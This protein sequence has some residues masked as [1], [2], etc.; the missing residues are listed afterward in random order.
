MNNEMKILIPNEFLKMNSMPND[1][2]QST[3][4]GKQT[5]SANCFLMVYPIPIQNAMPFGNN[6]AV[7]N[8]IHQTLGND[9]GLIEVGSGN[10]VNGK[11]YIYSIVKTKMNP[12][13]V[14]YCLVMHIGENNSVMQ[15]QGF[16]DEVGMTGQR[17]S[18]IYNKLMNEGRLSA[19]M[20]GWMCDPYD[21]NYRNGLLM[22]LSEKRDYDMMFPQHPLSECRNFV[23]YVIEHN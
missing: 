13:G 8:G 19:D 21:S 16:F 11:N 20:S 18:M 14:Q 2:P 5:Q 4:Y 22:N 3:P 10:T 1:P 7:I 9:Q 17:D 6:N 12:S 23:K 15:I